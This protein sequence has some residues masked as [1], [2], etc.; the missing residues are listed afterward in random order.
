MNDQGL[1]QPAGSTGGPART[2]AI[3]YIEDSSSNVAEMRALMADLAGVQLLTADTAERGL[4]VARAVKPDAVVINVER[5]GMA[6]IEAAAALRSEPETRDIAVFSLL[7]D[8]TDVSLEGLQRYFTNPI[9]AGE[10]PARLRA[11]LAAR[12]D[13]PERA[14]A[15]AEKRPRRDGIGA[16]APAPDSWF[17]LRR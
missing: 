16:E 8:A 11:V 2:P 6:G 4:E 5:A 9:G 13:P 3:L 14:R 12:R 10:L 15:L 17:T 1:E 7:W